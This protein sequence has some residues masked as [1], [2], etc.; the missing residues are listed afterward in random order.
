MSKLVDR[1]E[2]QRF[3]LNSESWADF[4][5]RLLTKNDASTQI[6]FLEACRSRDS[7]SAYI[8]NTLK[9]KNLNFD[10]SI[11]FDHRFTQNEFFSPP[12]DTQKLIWD[13]FNQYPHEFMSDNCFWGGIMLELIDNCDFEPAWLAANNGE[14]G[15]Y[16]IDMAL[17]SPENIKSIDNCVRRILRSMCHPRPRGKRVVYFDFP[18][19]KSWWRYYWA[20]KMSEHI[21]V[22]FER[23][24]EIM[25]PSIYQALVERMHSSRSYISFPN[26]FGGMLL[27]L[28]EIPDSVNHK[29]I[30]KI[31]NHLAY[32]I[33]WNSIEIQEPK[34]I[35]KQISLVSRLIIE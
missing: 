11:F 24:L 20:N 6:E 12:E 8:S 32:L 31:A 7:F 21:S 22:D 35:C 26:V 3:C 13:T 25:D 29:D 33:I 16:S 27:F 5:Q 15:D 30:G 28:D 23:I 34:L 9:P 10:T 14:D 18:L 1:E 17:K 2:A 19:G 4:G